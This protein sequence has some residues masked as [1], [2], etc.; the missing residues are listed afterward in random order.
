MSYYRP[1]ALPSWMIWTG[2]AVAIGGV[3]LGLGSF[4]SGGLSGVGEAL[5]ATS[6]AAAYTPLALGMLGSLAVWRSTEKA[7]QIRRDTNHY[8]RGL[9]DALSHGLS[10]SPLPARLLDKS[11]QVSWLTTGL[12]LTMGALLAVAGGFLVVSGLL[13]GL[14]SVA[15]VAPNLLGGLAMMGAGYTAWKVGS[16]ASE[17]RAFAYSTEASA[18]RGRI[19]EDLVLNQTRLENAIRAPAPERVSSVSTPLTDRFRSEQGG[20]VERLASEKQADMTLAQRH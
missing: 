13:G 12:S 9:Q 7:D 6:G 3:V 5:S 1:P 10:D 16:V 17:A 4:A 15:S 20:F 2:R 8:Q 19:A 11:A 18:E 14:T